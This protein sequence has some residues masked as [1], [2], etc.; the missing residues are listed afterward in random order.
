MHNTGI[1]SNNTAGEGSG[2]LEARL[3]RFYQVYAP[4]KLDNI[5]QIIETLKNGS[6]WQSHH[7]INREHELFQQLTS[8]YGPEPPAGGE[9]FSNPLQHFCTHAVPD[10]TP[11]GGSRPDSAV[12]ACAAVSVFTGGLPKDVILPWD[13]LDT[14][15]AALCSPLI[16]R[17]VSD[18][19]AQ[20]ALFRCPAVT[21]RLRTT[22]ADA[23]EC[24]KEMSC[25]SGRWLSVTVEL[26][27]SVTALPIDLEEEWKPTE[28]YEWG[29]RQRVSCFLSDC[30][31]LKTVDLR[32][33]GLQRIG[34]N[35]A[36]ACPHLTTV[37]L[38]DTL[39]EVR[40]NFVVRCESL[41]RLDLRHTGLQ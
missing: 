25:S 36:H 17:N 31:T 39:T 3:T 28:S 35:F 6:R 4:D 41:N 2:S 11:L 29:N 32:N 27:K 5:P 40:D 21:V 14:A 7:F 30:K 12:V 20:E 9:G 24:L 8:E 38:P 10:F 37:A 18:L 16:V 15:L 19:R 22:D 23:L 33:T 13:V 34:E 1:S 26:D